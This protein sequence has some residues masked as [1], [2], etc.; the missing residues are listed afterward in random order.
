MLETLAIS[1]SPPSDHI[2]ATNNASKKKPGRKPNPASPALRKAQNR[3]A[4]RAFRERKERHIIE[5]EET[6]KVLREQRDRLLS[7]NKELRSSVGVLG[8]E[9][10][11]LKGLVL[12]LQL[13][14]LLQNVEIPNHTPYLEHGYLRE[15]ML[16]TSTP[17]I[18]SAYV[19]AKEMHG[20]PSTDKDKQPKP[21]PTMASPHRGQYLSTGVIIVGRDSVRTVIG[22]RISTRIRATPPP[23]PPRPP[24]QQ[25]TQVLTASSTSRRR[26]SMATSTSITSSM[27]NDEDEDDASDNEEGS[28]SP[29]FSARPIMLT[30]EP[31]PSF[32][33][34]SFQ[35]MRL[36]L[37]LQAVCD[38]MGDGTFKLEPTVLQLTVPHDLRIDLIPVAAMRDRM[39][40]F[41]DL[42]DVDDCFRILLDGMV[43]EEGDPL[44]PSSW[45]FPVE[46]YEKFW[47]L[48]H[49]YSAEEIKRRWPGLK[50]DRVDKLLDEVVSFAGESSPLQHG[51]FPS[52]ELAT[53]LLPPSMSNFF[54]N[55]DAFNNFTIDQ[56]SHYPPS[57]SSDGV[58]STS[59]EGDSSLMEGR[60]NH[61]TRESNT[62]KSIMIPTEED[63]NDIPWDDV[64]SL[65]VNDVEMTD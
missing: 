28:K 42:Y 59:S 54:E 14:C 23:Q 62:D 15:S 20:L 39:I 49:D 53:G 52:N 43:Y 5:L 38:K 22:N 29:T 24:R 16:N 40:L 47:F 3:A 25:E 63:N 60:L 13:V 46:F 31:I 44:K 12:S 11:H 26:S 1:T 37:Q 19:K 56:P 2:S 17:E 4:Q 61:D 7:E 21:P 50:K 27:D 6:S 58:F 34:A 48:T 35:T 33:L 8:Y 36:R 57:L 41:H 64:V 32:N 10:W 30:R 18:I 65:N 51:R 45:K 55:P 9:G